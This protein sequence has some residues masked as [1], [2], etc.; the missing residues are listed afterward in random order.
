MNNSLSLEEHKM[1]CENWTPLILPVASVVIAAAGMFIA[2]LALRETWRAPRYQI[3][4]DLMKDYAQPQMAD[5]VS[6]LWD[7][8]EHTCKS[9]KDTVKE[10]FTM[11]GRDDP[12]KLDQARRRVSHFYKR[13][14]ILWKDSTWFVNS[15]FADSIFSIWSDTDLRIIPEIIIP[16]ENAL[17]EKHGAKPRDNEFKDLLDLYQASKQYRQAVDSKHS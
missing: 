15:L 17:L 9:N 6:S 1:D 13:L 4:S 12:L 3:L 8:Y 16:L 11:L 7:F 5:A 2:W 10:Q 14:A